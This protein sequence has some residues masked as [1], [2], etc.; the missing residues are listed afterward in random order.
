MHNYGA[1]LL[2]VGFVP[3]DRDT[4]LILDA[5]GVRFQT[6][7]LHSVQVVLLV[8][9]IQRKV[10]LSNQFYK[11]YAL[12]VMPLENPSLLPVAKPTGL[13]EADSSFIFILSRS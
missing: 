2:T 11:T 6:N 5:N 10:S 1:T 9:K 8:A 12:N 4:G 7:F 3:I 13:V